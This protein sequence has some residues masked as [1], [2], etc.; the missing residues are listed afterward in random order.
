MTTEARI[1]QLAITDEI[2]EKFCTH[3]EH[4]Q[5]V[6]DVFTTLPVRHGLEMVAIDIARSVG[7]VRRGV[8]GQS[9][10]DDNEG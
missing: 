6:E 3:A 8:R 4:A 1:A 2:V 7:R 9:V 5:G 10:H